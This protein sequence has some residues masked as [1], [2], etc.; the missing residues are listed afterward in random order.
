M[1]AIST[2]KIL[3]VDDDFNIRYIL[4]RFLKRKGY[5]VVTAGNSD[6][7]FKYLEIEKPDIILLDIVM[8][9]MGGIEVLHRIRNNYPDAVVLM[10]TGLRDK[11]IWKLAF[12]EG[13][14]D[15]IGKPVRF[16]YLDNVIR[17]YT[18]K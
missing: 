4:S 5:R 13:C 15:Y 1:M 7:T 2:K 14:K 10:I 12:E 8:E 18:N 3:I 6:D 16:D 17:M 9:G 11:Q